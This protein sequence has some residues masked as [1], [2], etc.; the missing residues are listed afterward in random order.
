MGSDPWTCPKRTQTQG[1]ARLPCRL[2]R[3]AMSVPDMAGGQTPGHVPKGHILAAQTARRGYSVLEAEVRREPVEP[4]LAA[5]AG[6]LVA[7]ERRRRVEAVVRVRPDHAGAQPRRHRQDPRALLRP[8]AGREAVRRVVR[9]LDR[10]VGSAE[11]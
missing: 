2:L 9:L 6:L 5:E 8:D 1:Q 4:A 10:L 3:P 11:R 7:A